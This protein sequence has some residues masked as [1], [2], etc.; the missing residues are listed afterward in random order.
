MQ[1]HRSLKKSTLQNMQHVHT[2]PLSCVEEFDHHCIWLNT[3]IGKNNYISFMVLLFSIAINFM[4]Y[5]A[6]LAVLWREAQW[7]MYFAS[8][9]VAWSASVV[10]V[11]I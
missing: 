6:G 1:E 3:C 11:I 8:M 4:L 5:L 2:S 9:V 10:V 7:N